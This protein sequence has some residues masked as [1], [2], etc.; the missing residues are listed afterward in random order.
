MYQPAPELLSSKSH[1]MKK[2]IKF[3]NKANFLCFYAELDRAQKWRGRET[4]QIF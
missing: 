1:K 4:V 2:R 3:D